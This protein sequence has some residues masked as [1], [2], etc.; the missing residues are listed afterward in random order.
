MYTLF[1][2]EGKIVDNKYSDVIEYLDLTNIKN[3]WTKMD[4]YN[5]SEAKLKTLLKIFPLSNNLLLAY[6][7]ESGRHKKKTVC[8]I[9]LTR[10]EITKIDKQLAEQLKIE[11]KKSLKLNNIVS[12]LNLN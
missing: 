2:N 9:N 11:S 8:V 10:G 7:G 12:S 4:Y 1:G 6:G 5:T 3:G